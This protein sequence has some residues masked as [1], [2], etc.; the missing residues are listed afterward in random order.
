MSAVTK[1]KTKTKS[2]TSPKSATTL[3]SAVGGRGG[4]PPPAK[5]HSDGQHP[6]EFDLDLTLPPAD[7]KAW[8]NTLG[9]SDVKF[10]VDKLNP[11][12]KRVI[13]V[14]KKSPLDDEGLCGAN[15][16]NVTYCKH[17]EDCD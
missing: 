5:H 11:I 3:K 4:A 12:L 15:Y 10:M 17:D 6:H 2:K 13:E 14:A 7:L 1:S 9:P 8:F 16:H